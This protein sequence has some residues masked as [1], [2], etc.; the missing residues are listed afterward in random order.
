M[1]NN[2]QDNRIKNHG[3]ENCRDIKTFEYLIVTDVGS[4]H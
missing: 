2:K 1:S 3:Q 4:A